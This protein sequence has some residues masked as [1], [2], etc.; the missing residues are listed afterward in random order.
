[1]GGGKGI[2]LGPAENSVA[3]EEGDGAKV[4]LWRAVVGNERRTGDF[5]RHNLFA[6]RSGPSDRWCGVG[7]GCRDHTQSASAIHFRCMGRHSLVSLT[8]CT[9]ARN[10]A[11]EAGSSIVRTRKTTL[12]TV[13]F[14]AVR[15]SSSST[16]H[17]CIGRCQRHERVLQRRASHS[18]SSRVA[19]RAAREQGARPQTHR[20]CTNLNLHGVDQVVS[21]TQPST[22]GATFECDLPTCARWNR[23][24]SEGGRGRRTLRFCSSAPRDLPPHATATRGHSS[25]LCTL[26][27][28]SA[29]DL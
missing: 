15:S 1:M 26:G 20:K 5:D 3:D 4:K 13:C 22:D 29:G 10:D 11:C 8:K 23:N 14:K 2:S 21:T 17:H 27:C 25:N 19:E 6:G 28:R 9:L 24:Q 12:F 18:T 7:V 16:T